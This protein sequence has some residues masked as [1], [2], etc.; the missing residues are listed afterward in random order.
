MNTMRDA[1]VRVKDHTNQAPPRKIK[2][3]TI[4][5]TGALFHA[6]GA[7]AADSFLRK[8]LIRRSP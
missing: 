7:G 3:R 2:Y 5:D 8:L 6:F 4:T 1:M